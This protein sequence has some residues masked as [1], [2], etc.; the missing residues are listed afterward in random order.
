MSFASLMNNRRFE[1]SEIDSEDDIDLN[2][3]AAAVMF[4][5]IAAD[6]E[7]AKIEIAC[8]VDLLRDRYSLESDDLIDIMISARRAADNELEISNFV[9]LLRE[10]LSESERSLFLDDLW[11]LACSDKKIRNRERLAIDSFADAL[12]LD[13]EVV[14]KARDMA[15]KKLELNLN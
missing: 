10:N 2:L 7:V 6:D 8:L 15:E 13:L 1:L 12:D 14:A 11:E 5:V 4:A 3:A 9:N